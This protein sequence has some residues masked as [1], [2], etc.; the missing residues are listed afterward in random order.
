M[1]RLS[2]LT[3]ESALP[4][5]I[6]DFF[7]SVTNVATLMLL[8]KTFSIS[9]FYNMINWLA[10]EGEINVFILFIFFNM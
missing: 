9:V 7:S 10:F 4:R 3:P 5:R 6:K 2:M 8:I 1:F